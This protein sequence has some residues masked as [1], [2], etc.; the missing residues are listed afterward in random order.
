MPPS[1]EDEQV[2]T[3]GP[4]RTCALCRN[5]RPLRRSHL[6]PAALYRLLLWKEGTNPSPLVVS[7]HRQDRTSRQVQDHLMCQAC[8]QLFSA[9]GESWVLRKCCRGRSGA[10][11]LRDE[12]LAEPPAVDYGNGLTEYSTAGIP[13][14]FAYL[15]YFALSVF[16]RAVVNRWRVLGR[17]YEPISLGPYE[18]SIRHFLLGVGPFPDRAALTVLISNAPKPMQSSLAP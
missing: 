1:H 3:S 18:E 12:V 17:D 13:G 14:A 4:V 8:E 5:V 9:K 16:W 15:T 11:E 7:E 2:K 6:L 10:F